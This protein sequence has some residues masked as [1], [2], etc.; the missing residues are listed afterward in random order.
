MASLYESLESTA[1]G[2]RDLADARLRYQVLAVLHAAMRDA[3]STQTELAARLGVRKSAVNQ[4]L[5]GDGNL[6]MSTAAQ[7]LAALGF[8]LGVDLYPIG[9]QRR[10]L[11]ED[12]QPETARVGRRE[13]RAQLVPTHGSIH[14]A[15][16]ARSEVSKVVSMRRWVDA[17][18]F[19][20]RVHVER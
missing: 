1:E 20:C 19:G 10:A 15:A 5:R 3:G 4:V 13:P 7:Y 17:G 8:E 6:R 16:A 12:R 18:R 14:V 9:E 11:L 2:V